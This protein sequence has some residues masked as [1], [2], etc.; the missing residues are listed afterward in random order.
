MVVNGRE[1]AAWQTGRSIGPRVCREGER[2]AHRAG[3]VCRKVEMG[4][5]DL[6]CVTSGGRRRED[7][8]VE[9]QNDRIIRHRS[10]N[11]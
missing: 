4:K 10:Q 2:L 5:L 8:R 6:I 3:Q 7:Q 1:A 9:A 11:E